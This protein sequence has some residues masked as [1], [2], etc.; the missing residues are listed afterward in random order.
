VTW[1]SGSIPTRSSGWQN[2]SADEVRAT[3]DHGE[4]YEAKHGRT[5]FRRNFAYD[6]LTWRDRT[7]SAK[8]VEAIAVI[9]EGEWLVITVLAKYF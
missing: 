2:G 4:R 3:I 9:E 6:S 8:Q 1:K 7:Y 5:G